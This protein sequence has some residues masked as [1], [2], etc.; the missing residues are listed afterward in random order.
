MASK[1]ATA[2]SVEEMFA[3]LTAQIELLSGVPANIAKLEALVLDLTK[4]NISLREELV[5][6]NKE[7]LFLKN[8][9]N[10]VDQ[11]N[12]SWSVRI[13]NIPIPP[14]DSRNNFKVAKI[15]YDTVLLPI[16]LGAV[17]AGEIS[18]VPPCHQLLERAHI[19]PGSGDKMGS[20]IARFSNRDYRQLV[21]KYKRDYQPR[22]SAPLQPTAT[23]RAT[24]R[25]SG[26]PLGRFLYPIHE[27]L[28]KATFSKMRALSAHTS[29]LSA[30]TNNGSIR[31]KLANDSSNTIHRVNNVFDSVEQILSQ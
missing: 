15:A 13:F 26:K 5:E 21:F 17:A 22:E 27:D 10:T 28:T 18:D 7:I 25:Q 23:T 9:V 12:R 4:E 16:L 20:V 29:V 6:K 8:H 2:K 1:K 24:N 19:L 3:S 30:W 31:Y 14:A 11:Y